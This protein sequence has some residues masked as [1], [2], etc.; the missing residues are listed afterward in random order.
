MHQISI[1]IGIEPLSLQSL[2]KISALCKTSGERVMELESLKI[3]RDLFD[4]S[5]FF[6][7]EEIEKESDLYRESGL[8]PVAFYLKSGIPL[9]GIL[10]PRIAPFEDCP[11]TTVK[12]LKE[13]LWAMNDETRSKEARSCSCE[14]PKSLVFDKGRERPR[15]E[16]FFC[17]KVTY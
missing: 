17:R 14:D 3:L 1:E 10:F 4:Q 6:R 11:Q 13:G 8:G 7:D 5:P 15:L 12:D 16:G 2:C 9:T